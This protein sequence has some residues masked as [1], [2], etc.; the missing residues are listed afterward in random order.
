MLIAGGKDKGL[1]YTPLAGLLRERTVAA[2]TFGE[3]G[4][5][6]GEVFSQAVETQTVSTLEEAVKAA[7]QLAKA[8]STVLFSPGTSSF[9]QF[10]SYV[11]RG[12]A[13]RNYVNQLK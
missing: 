12:D 6:L 11:E 13:F 2:V 1:D 9:D 8:G 7:Q 4:E 10:S 5:Q 3:I